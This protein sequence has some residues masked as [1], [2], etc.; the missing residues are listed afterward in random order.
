MY[1]KQDFCV[2]SFACNSE[3]IV[4]QMVAVLALLGCAGSAQTC[5]WSARCLMEAIPSVSLPKRLTRRSLASGGEVHC[6]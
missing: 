5:T 3:Y 2:A 1:C 6:R 4:N